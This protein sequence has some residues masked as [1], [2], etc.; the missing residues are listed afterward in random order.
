LRL[1]LAEL[2]AGLLSCGAA[3]A[4]EMAGLQ[5]LMSCVEEPAP[6]KILLDLSAAGFLGAR[7]GPG[8][9]DDYCWPLISPLEWGGATF[10]G[11]CVVTDDAKAISA[12]PEFFWSGSLAPW[13]EVWLT[14]TIAPADL[15]RWA[16]EN[17]PAG[18]RY[19]I[20]R[21][22]GGAGGGALSCSAWH[23]PLPG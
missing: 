16:R 11:L 22:D 10:G 21:V 2:A 15:D 9:D 20:D 12:H 7:S 6:T 17:L 4:S 5:A 3:Q 23:F 1:V 13:T 14:S 8:G 18:S 19:E